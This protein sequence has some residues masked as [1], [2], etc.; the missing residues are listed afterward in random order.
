MY[1]DYVYEHTVVLLPIFPSSWE[2]M[3]GEGKFHA[4]LIEQCFLLT[5]LNVLKVVR[6]SFLNDLFE[7]NVN[8]IGNS[9]SSGPGQKNQSLFASF[10]IVC[11]TEKTVQSPC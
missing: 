9:C 4:V 1:A 6:Y 8:A 2:M 11:Y 10:A 3:R 5:V 7:N